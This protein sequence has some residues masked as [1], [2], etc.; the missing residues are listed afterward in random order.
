MSARIIRNIEDTPNLMPI[1]FPEH[2]GISPNARKRPAP[3]A[4]DS[5]YGKARTEFLNK[6]F[7]AG[8]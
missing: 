1:Q 5:A 4:T 3:K 6:L 8:D 2:T 7:A